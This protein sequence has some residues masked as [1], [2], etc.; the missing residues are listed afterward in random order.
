MV[1]DTRAVSS[2]GWISTSW[3]I[4]DPYL[5]RMA[6]TQ[7][8]AKSADIQF[9]CPATGCEV[10]SVPSPDGVYVWESMTIREGRN[11]LMKNT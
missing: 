8:D 9:P 5:E 7:L 10:L 11:E 4:D 2:S 3:V 6:A 1:H